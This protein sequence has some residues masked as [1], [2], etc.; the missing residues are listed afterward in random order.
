MEAKFWLD[1]VRLVRSRGLRSKD[2]SQI[3]QLVAKHQQH[4]LEAWDEFFNG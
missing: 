1:P 2:I 4:L 3:Q